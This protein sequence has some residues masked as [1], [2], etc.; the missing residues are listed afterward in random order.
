M[1]L[2]RLEGST[3]N[4]PHNK[5]RF[6]LVIE[7]MAYQRAGRILVEAGVSGY[8]VIPALAGYGNGNT[9]QRDTDI[10]GSNDMVVII[11]ITDEETLGVIR[12]KMANLLSSHIGVIGIS[13]VTVL[14]PEKF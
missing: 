10:S 8:T 13:D 9:W 5:K 12:E 11:S 1:P 4:M 14:R 6:E 2:R 3:S 7:R